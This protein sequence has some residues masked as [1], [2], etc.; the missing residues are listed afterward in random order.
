VAAI[1][2]NR[3]SDDYNIIVRFEVQISIYYDVTY[4]YIYIIYNIIRQVMHCVF[5]HQ[6]FEIYFVCFCV[7]KSFAL[8]I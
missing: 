8:Q 2:L 3:Q 6:I 4:A 1:E 5:M 7:L